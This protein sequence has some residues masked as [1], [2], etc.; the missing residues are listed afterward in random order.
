MEKEIEWDRVK[1]F[2]PNEFVD[3]VDTLANPELIYTLDA[4]RDLVGVKIFPSPVPGSCARLHGSQTSQHFAFL[5]RSTAIDVFCEGSPLSIFWYA[6]GCRMWGGIGVY[7]DTVYRGKV[8]T[9][10]HFDIRPF[11]KYPKLWVRDSGVYTETRGKTLYT[12][13]FEEPK[14]MTVLVANLINRS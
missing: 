6:M 2:A 10:F 13:P 12:Y 11:S 3:N 9:M 1:N 14:R 7:F 8:H 5:R 4:F